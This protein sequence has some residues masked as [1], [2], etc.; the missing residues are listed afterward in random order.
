MSNTGSVLML[1]PGDPEL[2]HDL[3]VRVKAILLYAGG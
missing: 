1:I 3:P 2:H